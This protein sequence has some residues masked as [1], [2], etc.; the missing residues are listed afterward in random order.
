M[1]QLGN[2]VSMSQLTPFNSPFASSDFGHLEQ[3][4]VALE[5]AGCGLVAL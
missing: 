1:L 5:Q 2:S 3:E 4:I